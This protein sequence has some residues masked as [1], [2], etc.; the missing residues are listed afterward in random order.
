M[1]KGRVDVRVMRKTKRARLRFYGVSPDQLE[2]ILFALE[3]ARE[4]F[5]TEWDTVA[6]DG[7]C[8]SYI[9]SRLG[10]TQQ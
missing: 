3:Q 2:L 5:G 4:E 8:A 9:E 6:L 1:P 10:K 7:I